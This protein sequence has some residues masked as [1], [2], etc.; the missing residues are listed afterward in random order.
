MEEI[1]KQVAAYEGQEI[2][3]AV[4]RVL[5][6]PDFARWLYGTTERRLPKLAQRM[7]LGLLRHS[8]NPRQIVDRFLVYPFMRQTK[9]ASIRKLEITGLENLDHKVDG[10]PHGQLFLTNHR[11]I[12]L[13]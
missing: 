3:A 10:E 12:I 8:D 11:D 9:R 5:D 1:Y 4:E 2:T 13:D 7:I 6:D